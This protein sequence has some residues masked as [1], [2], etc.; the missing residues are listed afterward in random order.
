MGVDIHVTIEGL[1]LVAAPRIFRVSAYH[2]RNNGILPLSALRYRL[3]DKITSYLR[4]EEEVWIYIPK[5]QW[6]VNGKGALSCAAFRDYDFFALIGGNRVF[7][8]YLPETGPLP[9]PDWSEC[10][11]QR[12]WPERTMTPE[13]TALLDEGLWGFRTYNLPSLLLCVLET[14]E[15]EAVRESGLFKDGILHDFRDELID[16]LGLHRRV[17]RPVWV[18][19]ILIA[20][21]N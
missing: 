12:G 20:F 7:E 4:K 21:D 8:C 5:E 16:L 2:S 3:I 6:P 18:V 17:W 14:L 15:E 9:G 13:A 10:C 1:M 11:G 19:R